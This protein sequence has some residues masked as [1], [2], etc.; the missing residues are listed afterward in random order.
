MHSWVISL[1]AGRHK[2]LAVS[3]ILGKARCLFFWQL[4]SQLVLQNQVLFWLI[5]RHSEVT[6]Y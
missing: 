5:L 2:H 3:S 1:S 4:E 6:R